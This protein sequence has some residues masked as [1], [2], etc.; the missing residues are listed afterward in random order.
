MVQTKLRLACAGS[1]PPEADPATY[2][3]SHIEFW[4]KKQLEL[5]Y[6]IVGTGEPGWRNRYG[7]VER[8]TQDMEGVEIKPK[9]AWAKSYCSGRIKPKSR[10]EGARE[11]AEN[12]Y[13]ASIVPVGVLRKAT[14]TDPVTIGIELIAN[15]PMLARSYPEIYE[16]VTDALRPIVVA[17]SDYVEIVQ[18]DCPSH[19][20][21]PTKEPWRYVNELSKTVGKRTWIHVDGHVGQMLP[22]LIKEYDVDVLNVNLFGREEEA[23]FKAIAESTRILQD[24]GKKLAPAVVNTQ[25]GDQIEEVESVESISSRVRRLSRHL[26]VDMLEAVT[27]GCGLRLLQNAAQTILERLRA[28]V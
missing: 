2:P 7:M 23:N 28:A 9:G 4:L 6:A 17:V 26:S 16:D 13:L 11:I 12:K 5:Q 10:P 18:F 20:A 25:I 24:E 21:R 1:L 27:T 15:N 19:V 8:F 14:I 22:V 3:F